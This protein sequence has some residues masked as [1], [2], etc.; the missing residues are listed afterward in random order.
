MKLKIIFIVSLLASFQTYA[1]CRS[2]YV[3]Q[4]FKE[5]HPCPKEFI[6]NGKCTAI[7]DHIC[8]LFQ[9]GKDSCKNSFRE[10]NLQWQSLEDSKTKDLYEN[11]PIGK[12]LFCTPYNSTP[13]RQVFNCK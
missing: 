10:C 1:A 11:K 13:T 9:G 8:P 2:S 5:S 12:L 7:V 4:Q 6:I 3:I